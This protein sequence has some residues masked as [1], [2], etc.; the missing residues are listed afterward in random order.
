MI[1]FIKRFFGVTPLIPPE[2]FSDAIKTA[3]D[4][5]QQLSDATERLRAYNRDMEALRRD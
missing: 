1:R 3:E 5:R 4:Q 2:P